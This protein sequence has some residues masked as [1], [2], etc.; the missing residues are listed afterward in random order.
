MALATTKT[1]GQYVLLVEF[2]P[3][4]GTYSK[5]CGLTSRGVQR[6]LSLQE[7]QVP[8]C[9]NEDLPAAI[10]IAPQSKQFNISGSGVMSQEAH[11]SLLN[12]FNLGTPRNVRIKTTGATSGQVDYEQGSAYLTSYG[13]A[14]E[15]GQV[16]NADLAIRIDGVMTATLVP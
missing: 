13:N 5:V 9:D 2:T 8:D 7:T 11:L 14:A 16:V 12:W 1:F 10:Q 4:S 15:K 6:E 3:G